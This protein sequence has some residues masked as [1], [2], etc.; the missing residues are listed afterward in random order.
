MARSKVSCVRKVGIAMLVVTSNETI[1]KLLR[2]LCYRVILSLHD[3]KR[4]WIVELC[5]Y[6]T[7]TGSFKEKMESTKWKER[8]YP[9]LQLQA[10]IHLTYRLPFISYARQVGSNLADPILSRHRNWTFHLFRQQT[11]KQCYV[12]CADLCDLIQRRAV[13]GVK[14]DNHMQDKVNRS[15]KPSGSLCSCR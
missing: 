12:T 6:S 7:W 11:W 15:L 8:T 4:R 9:L 2:S 3:S 1:S 14:Y 10:D 13:P 5:T